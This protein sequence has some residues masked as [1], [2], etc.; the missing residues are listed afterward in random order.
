MQSLNFLFNK[1]SLKNEFH[2]NVQNNNNSFL[3]SKISILQWF[4]KDY[5]VI[6]DWCND[7]EN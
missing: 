1:E 4:P 2:T 5:Y 7:A 3:S 6:E